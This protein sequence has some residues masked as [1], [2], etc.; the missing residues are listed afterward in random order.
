[1]RTCGAG[2]FECRDSAL[3]VVSDSLDEVPQAPQGLDRFDE[4]LQ[5][6]S[7]T[8]LHLGDLPD[9]SFVLLA[10]HAH[11]LDLSRQCVKPLIDL[12]KPLIDLGKPLIDLGKPLIDLSEPFIDLS[13]PLIDLSELP[14][15]LLETF[16]H[17]LAEPCQRLFDF[18]QPLVY[19]WHRNPPGA[20]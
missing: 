15:D 8:D 12:I 17:P 6:F 18:D 13:E 2:G 20:G 10:Q 14:I 9:L 5:L 19:L 11:L 7:M 3:V 16:I 4:L 1:V